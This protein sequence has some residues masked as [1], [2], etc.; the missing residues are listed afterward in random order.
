MT[1]RKRSFISIVMAT[2]VLLSLCAVYAT[3]S[4]GAA[5]SGSSRASVQASPDLV[6]N[7]IP[8]STS[9]SDCIPKVLP[10]QFLFVK[11]YDGA[12]WYN[13]ENYLLSSSANWGWSG[14]TSLGGQLTSSPC[15]VWRSPGILDV[16]VRGTDGALWS[17]TTAN[18]GASWSNW[19]TIGGQLAS[20]TGAGACS[21][22]AGREDVFVEGTDGALLQNTWTAASGWS[23]WVS[24]GGQLT[25]SPA[26]VSRGAGL[27]D[28]CVRGADGAVWHKSYNNGWSGW[29]SV[30]GALAPGTG[31][32][33][34]AWRVDRSS[35]WGSYM[36]RLDVWVTGTNGAVWQKTW[37]AASGWTHWT[38]LG[39]QLTSSP[40]VAMQK[41][42]VEV[43]ARSPN[44]YIYLDE[45]CAKWS[46]WMGGTMQGP[47]GYF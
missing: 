18:N 35:A 16:Y 17:R 41:Y 20:G 6:G 39:G 46:G 40:T 2:I 38:S 25:S 4:M 44:G 13:R 21:W 10:Y 23:G 47:P 26:A 45:Y 31:P 29:D 7:P 30:G 11:G 33:L 32:A 8:A 42:C 12:L 28:V 37:T 14:W 24:L 43:W 27:I 15:A 36:D 34:S 19:S 22:G 9:P 5:S 3:T 1:K